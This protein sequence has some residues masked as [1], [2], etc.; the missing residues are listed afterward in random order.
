VAYI[1]DL[2]DYI[3]LAQAI[4]GL[5]EAVAV[6]GFRAEN[7]RSEKTTPLRLV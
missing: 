2:F 3:K 6:L 5:K 7:G 1:I 4:E